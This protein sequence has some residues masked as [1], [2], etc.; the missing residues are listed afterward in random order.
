MI[1]Y[2]NYDL[3]RQ[4]LLFK[5]V[6]W[7]HDLL[8]QFR[9]TFTAN[10]GLNCPVWKL[11]LVSEVLDNQ[12][13]ICTWLWLNV[14]TFFHSSSRFNYWFDLKYRSCFCLDQILIINAKCNISYLLVLIDLKYLCNFLLINDKWNQII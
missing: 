13:I 8:R 2:K 12:I 5:K 9:F 7:T 10:H 4:K 11:L 1:N 3:N 6:Y 14:D